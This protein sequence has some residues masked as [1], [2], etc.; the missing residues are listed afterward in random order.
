MVLEFHKNSGIETTCHSVSMLLLV[1][2]YCE[3]LYSYR[4]SRAENEK[5]NLLLMRKCCEG[6]LYT[7]S[8]ES[9]R[10]TE[11]SESL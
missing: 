7:S 9:Y 2:E 5:K 4:G 8:K 6:S 10:I 11:S 1:L 3:V